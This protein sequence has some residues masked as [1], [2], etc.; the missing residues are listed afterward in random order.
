MSFQG[1]D[2]TDAR[3]CAKIMKSLYPASLCR[4][5]SYK[6][7]AILLDKILI[8]M[9][10]LN[11]QTKLFDIFLRD[12]IIRQMFIYELHDQQHCSINTLQCDTFWTVE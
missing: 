9:D 1:H 4:S 5:L 10:S 8:S 12:G 2:V 11:K 3:S 6:N 7:N